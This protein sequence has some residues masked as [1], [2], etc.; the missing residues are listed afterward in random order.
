MVFHFLL[1]LHSMLRWLVFCSLLFTSILA[2]IS[3]F[4]KKHFDQRH[5]QFVLSSQILVIL[6]VM[7]GIGLY[8][9][10]PLTAY[11]FRHLADGRQTGET[12][13]F[14]FFHSVVMLTVPIVTSVGVYRVKMAKPD[15]KKLKYM[16]VY[17]TL[18]LV[19]ALAFSP[20]PLMPV[21]HRPL[22]R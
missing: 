2:W 9:T 13:F 21:V 14:A 16:A 3:L 6:S 11:F 12:T 17:F 22:V 20:W 15:N 8:M 7:I 1:T 18:A 5:R 19:L 4:G 10:S